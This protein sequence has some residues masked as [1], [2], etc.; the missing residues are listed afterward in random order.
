MAP[1]VLQHGRNSWGRIDL[2]ARDGKVIS[3]LLVWIGHGLELDRG[4]G[5]VVDT[6]SHARERC[7]R[8]EEATHAGGKRDVDLS[9]QL[10]P[11]RVQFRRSKVAA[12]VARV[13]GPM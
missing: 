12:P 11:E 13:V 8:I 7:C 10:L 1:D 6:L 9:L 2:G 3:A 5:L 4:L